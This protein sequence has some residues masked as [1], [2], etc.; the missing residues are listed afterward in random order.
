[1]FLLR[2][3]LSALVTNWLLLRLHPLHKQELL[4]SFITATNKSPTPTANVF[5][6]VRDYMYIVLWNVWNNYDLFVE[7]CFILEVVLLVAVTSETLTRRLCPSREEASWRVI[8]TQTRYLKW[9]Q[10]SKPCVLKLFDIGKQ[11]S[12]WEQSYYVKTI[13]TQLIDG[14]RAL[15]LSLPKAVLRS[16]LSKKPRSKLKKTHIVLAMEYIA[17]HYMSLFRRLYPLA[18]YMLLFSR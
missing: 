2:Q 7:S 4:I 9:L 11:A 14:N 18:E 15:T 8:V 12:H 1:M 13:C 16:A 17:I 5:C 10:L 3:C 6:Q